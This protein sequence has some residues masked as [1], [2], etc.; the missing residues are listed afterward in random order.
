ADREEDLLRGLAETVRES[1]RLGSVTVEDTSGVVLTTVGE[2]FGPSLVVP[3][4]QPDRVTGRL[5]VT[6]RAGEHLDRRT[7]DGLR[8]LA[9]VLSIAVSSAQLAGEIGRSR[10]AL[11]TAREEERQVLRRELHDGLGPA[12]A[13]L[14]LGLHASS[15][16]LES[17]PAAAG[18]LLARLEGELD[19]CVE[20]VRRISR[21]L[22]PV[23][24]DELGLVPALEQMAERHAAGGM[25]VSVHADD[26]PPLSAAVSGA[27]YRIVSEALL[28]ASRHGEAPACEVRLEVGEDLVVEVADDG[29]GFDDQARPGVGLTSMGERAAE[30]GGVFEVE[31]P[32]SGGSLVRV[33]LPLEVRA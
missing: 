22:R 17:D 21:E 27:V 8:D 18:E 25:A 1:F 26:L 13:G 23:V 6:G 29:T 14:G 2:R 19:R 4:T 9:P 5:L 15:N 24:L 11:V 30:L 33:R 32:P 20:D 10:T 12:L 28:N 3:L 16:L 7:E 31:H